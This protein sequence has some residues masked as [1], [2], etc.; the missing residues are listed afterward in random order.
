M[1]LTVQINTAFAGDCEF[2]PAFTGLTGTVGVAIHDS[3][4]NV[5]LARTTSGITEDPTGSGAYN[6]LFSAIATTGY[7]RII[8]DTGG[9]NPVYAIEDLVIAGTTPEGVV[10]TGSARSSMGQLIARARQKIGDAQAT[11]F[12]DVEIQTCLDMWKHYEHRRGFYGLGYGPNWRYSQLIPEPTYS[13][14]PP[15]IQYLL[16][17]TPGEYWWES[18]MTIYDS[19]YN[20]LSPSSIDYLGGRVYFTSSQVPPVYALGQNY[21]FWNACADLVEEMIGTFML[22][23][24]DFST[25]QQQFHMSQ[26]IATLERVVKRYRALGEPQIITLERQDLLPAPGVAHRRFRR[27]L[28]GDFGGDV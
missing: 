20:L 11:I 19:G 28:R 1:S 2:G 18:D 3:S 13:G 17:E 6:S 9:S 15:T 25:D 7:Y 21:D 5:I 8:W 24:V 10:V 16:Y 22:N 26:R 4:N 27:Y 14:T 12:T 23:A